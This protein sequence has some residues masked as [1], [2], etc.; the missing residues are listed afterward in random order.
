VQEQP[1]SVPGVYATPGKDVYILLIGWDMVD[2]VQNATFK[3]YINPLINWVWIGGMIMMI[4][5]LV[6]AWNGSN[7]MK[8][9]YVLKPGVLVPNPNA[10]EV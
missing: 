5:T 2:K 3:I 1:V 8:A 6:A 7:Q 9:S 10:Q 4:G